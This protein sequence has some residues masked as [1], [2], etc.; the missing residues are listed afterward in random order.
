MD[1]YGL[2]FSSK[3]LADRLR[4]AL[5]KYQRQTDKAEL[6]TAYENYRAQKH[7]VQPKTV[8]S[9][10]IINAFSSFNIAPSGSKKRYLA[11]LPTHSD[12]EALQSD[13]NAVGEDLTL[14]LAGQILNRNR[15]DERK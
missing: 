12:V 9:E 8:L 6:R 10:R 5:E 7:E 4:N 2:K 14:V 15:G 3:K 11:V 1:N 13:W